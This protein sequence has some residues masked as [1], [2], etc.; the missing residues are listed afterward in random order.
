ML[1]SQG[2]CIAVFLLARVARLKVRQNIEDWIESARSNSSF[3]AASVDLQQPAQALISYGLVSIEQGIQVGP[4]LVPFTSTADR[5]TLF[6]I[7]RLLLLASPPL[8]LNLAVDNQVKRE[9]IPT[10]DM[11]ELSWLDPD[12]DAL[13]LEVRMAL[14]DTRQDDLRKELGSAAELIIISAL[15]AA[16]IDALHVARISDAF[17]YDIECHSPSIDRIEVKAASENTRGTFHLT[18]NEFDKSVEYPSQWRLVQVVF[19]NRAFVQRKLDASN[20]LGVFQ[21]KTGALSRV[22]PADSGAF[23]WTGSAEVHPMPDEWFQAS[24]KLAS[25]PSNE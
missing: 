10:W 19:M 4:A 1:P 15:S 8:W 11:Q 13:L 20:V 5:V 16:G 21:L 22:I 2:R 3:M 17:G 6:G 9:Y 23:R 14:G 25:L 18:R 7:A 12:L 24:I